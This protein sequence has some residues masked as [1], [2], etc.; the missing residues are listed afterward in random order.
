MAELAD[1]REPVHLGWPQTVGTFVAVA[2]AVVVA[3]MVDVGGTAVAVADGVAARVGV[4]LGATGS[5]IS[6]EYAKPVFSPASAR[7]P[8]PCSML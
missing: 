5:T 3:V 6:S 7:T 8:T 4:A 1:V 2:D